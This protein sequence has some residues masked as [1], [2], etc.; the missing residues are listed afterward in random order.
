MKRINEKAV[1]MN[2]VVLLI[3]EAIYEGLEEPVKKAI[4]DN[5]SLHE[6]AL[7][8]VPII[9]STMFRP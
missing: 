8:P 7:M 6:V 1:I 2:A 3:P 9:T 5:G 4:F